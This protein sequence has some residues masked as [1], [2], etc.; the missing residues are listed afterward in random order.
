MEEC[1]IVHGDLKKKTTLKKS[2]CSNENSIWV[3]Q[4]T[5]DFHVVFLGEN[6]DSR[7]PV[8]MAFESTR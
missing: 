3:K 8:K 5:P 2:A 1:M 4:D 6:K 7:D